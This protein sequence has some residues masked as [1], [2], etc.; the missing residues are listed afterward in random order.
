MLSRYIYFILL[1]LTVV[2]VNCAAAATTPYANSD[3]VYD[4]STLPDQFNELKKTIQE[5]TKRQTA[6]MSEVNGLKHLN[7]TLFA[8]IENLEKDKLEKK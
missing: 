1:S 5:L 2:L 3:S 4:I 8:R 7:E 6:L